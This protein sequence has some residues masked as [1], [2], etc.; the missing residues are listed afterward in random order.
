MLKFFV[1]EVLLLSERG[2][3]LSTERLLHICH[4]NVPYELVAI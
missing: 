4:K 3:L 2:P 1:T